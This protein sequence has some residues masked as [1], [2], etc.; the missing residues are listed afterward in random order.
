MAQGVNREGGQAGH[1]RKVE[2]V[3]RKTLVQ[4]EADQGTG[5]TYYCRFGI[6]PGG[7][8]RGFLIDNRARLRVGMGACQVLLCGVQVCQGGPGTTSHSPGQATGGP[9]ALPWTRE[10]GGGPHGSGATGASW[11]VLD[12]EDIF[13]DVRDLCN[14]LIANSGSGVISPHYIMILDCICEYVTG[15]INFL[16]YIVAILY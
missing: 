12:H 9:G 6:G 3:L 4:G 5:G 13:A 11:K 7:K 2:N 15:F 14:S 16:T 10:L 1:R 8:G